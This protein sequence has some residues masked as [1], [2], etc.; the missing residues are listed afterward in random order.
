MFIKNTDNK[1][2]NKDN[3][4][5]QNKKFQ[6]NN[7]KQYKKQF[8]K[9]YDPS[10]TK[11]EKEKIKVLDKEVK[12]IVKKINNA[13]KA[14]GNNEYDFKKQF[15]GKNINLVTKYGKNVQGIL[16][17]IDK[18][19]VL[20]KINNKTKYYYKHSLLEYYA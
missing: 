10:L 9:S 8:N 6:N 3:K 17:D 20:L 7:P 19:R 16:I 5:F 13:E 14:L 2:F 11:E 18:Y 15:S 1:G 12:D 4:K